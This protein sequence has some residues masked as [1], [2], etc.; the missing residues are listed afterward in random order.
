M[1]FAG[2]DQL[3]QSGFRE[4]AGVIARAAK[5]PTTPSHLPTGAFSQ[6]MGPWSVRL[7]ELSRWFIRRLA[8]ALP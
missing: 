6:L 3:P 2:E 8:R 4:A 7:G 1:L 5:T